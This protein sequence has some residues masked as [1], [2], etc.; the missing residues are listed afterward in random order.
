MKKIWKRWFTANR[1]ARIILAFLYTYISLTISLNHTCHQACHKRPEC[2]HEYTTHCHDF[3]CD[4]E[5]KTV[6]CEIGSPSTTCTDSQYCPACLYSLL[7]KSSEISQKVLPIV[8]EVVSISQ[9]LPQLNFTKQSEYL[10]SVSLR[11][12][13]CIIS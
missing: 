11:A 9:I 12:P 6:L 8:I 10:S 7:A 13:P 4:V 1:E 3:S 2:H 5:S